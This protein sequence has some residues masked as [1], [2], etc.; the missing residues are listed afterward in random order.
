MI[1]GDVELREVEA[2]I[3]EAEARTPRAST[4]ALLHARYDEIGGYQARSRAQTHARRAWASTTEAQAR[5][6]ASSPAAGAC[7]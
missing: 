1:D 5:H 6:V 4:L 3:A 2:A 7:A